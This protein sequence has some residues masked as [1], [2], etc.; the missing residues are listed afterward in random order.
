MSLANRIEVI[1]EKIEKAALNSGRKPDEVKLLGVTKFNSAEKIEEA[2]AAGLVLF[3][4]S[5][6]REAETK[7]PALQ[8]KYPAI[9]L[10]LIGNLQRNKVKNIPGIF[11]CV[12]SV[13][14]DPLI[15]ALG[16]TFGQSGTQIKVLLEMHTGEESKAGFPDTDA[17][18]RAAEK[19]L[20][21]PGLKLSGLMTMAPF[22][23]D[24]GAIRMAFRKLASAR[25]V[26]TRRFPEAD[27]S[28]LSM[29]MSGDFEIAIEEGSTLVRIGTAIFGDASAV[30]PGAQQ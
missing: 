24:S 30:S 16:K 9:S 26:L 21:F 2:I 1:K 10:H 4:E 14:R 19:A 29:G 13:D 25:G 15:D 20:A 8:K 27:F 18:S 17:L 7:Y 3:G 6:V 12:E 28:T 22:T 11:D 5:K 23:S